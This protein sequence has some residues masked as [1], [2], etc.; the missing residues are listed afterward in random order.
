MLAKVTELHETEQVRKIITSYFES[1]DKNNRDYQEE[2]QAEGTKKAYESDIRLFYRSIRKKPQRSELEQLHMSDLQISHQDFKDFKDLLFNLKKPDG[3][4]KY[5]NKT[6]NRKISSL[7]SFVKFL[8]EKGIIENISFLEYVK[9]EK[10]RK[11]SYAAFETDEVLLLSKYAKEERE[12]SEIK[13][14]LILFALD[15][16][17][18]KSEL[19]NIKWSDICEIE[20]RYIL[21][22]I[23][24][25]TKEFEKVISKS[26]YEK[27]LNIKNESEYV[28]D[29]KIDAVDKMFQRLV[30]KLDVNDHRKGNLVFHSIRKAGATHIYKVTKDLNQARIALCH[31]SIAT[32]QLYL[33]LS[34]YGSIGAVSQTEELDMDL[35]NKVDIGLLRKA[36]DNLDSSN[37]VV[38]IS[39]LTKLLGND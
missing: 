24:K 20:G 4:N 10:E 2:Y 18:R 16:C 30:K 22:G 15:S 39:E 19:I 12:K 31:S 26:M 5:V 14:T 36:L 27:L 6:V 38:L 7:K 33:G 21:K 32:T 13:S 3:K 37:K 34:E 11:N 28:F 8:G 23:G 1:L 9:S 29:I 35:Y 25:G 17:L